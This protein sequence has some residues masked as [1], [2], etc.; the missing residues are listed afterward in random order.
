MIVQFDVALKID[1]V[2]YSIYSYVLNFNALIFRFMGNYYV[3]LL[4]A[5]PNT[6]GL[7]TKRKLFNLTLT[8][9]S[10]AA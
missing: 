5:A 1:V 8:Q 6:I 2:Y 3:R 10:R 4:P 9:S 7:T